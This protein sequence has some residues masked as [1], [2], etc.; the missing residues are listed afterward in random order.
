VGTYHHS[1]HLPAERT[2]AGRRRGVFG[3]T[4][5]PIHIGHLVAAVN[6]R[7]AASLD[8]VL[9][10]VANEPWQKADREVTPARLR[11]A[12][13]EAAVAGVDGLVASDLE[14]RRGG[15]SYTADT[16]EALVEADPTADLFLV[17]GADV[18]TGLASW[19]RVD[20]VA[21]LATLVVVNRP[22]VARPEVDGRF[23]ALHVEVPALDISSSDL[24]ARARDG[25]PLDFL[26]P[27]GAIARARQLGLY[28]GGR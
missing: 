25:R 7:H 13:V 23:R 20:V 6:A 19:S 12:L 3:G 27:A 5:D 4:F 18:A 22:G 14:I 11:L 1:V 26:M 21:E 28:A 9:M 24:R 10:V 17:V 15:V 2:A 16:L 8:E